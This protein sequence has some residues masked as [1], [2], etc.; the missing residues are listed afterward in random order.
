MQ[1]D[2]FSPISDKGYWGIV[3]R[4]AMMFLYLFIYLRDTVIFQWDSTVIKAFAPSSSYKTSFML[5]SLFNIA[6]GYKKYL[7]KFC[8]EIW[9]LKYF[10]AGKTKSYR[11]H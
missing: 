4:M 7:P 9:I 11:W 2:K 5:G 8:L 3:I 10:T 1:A 6:G